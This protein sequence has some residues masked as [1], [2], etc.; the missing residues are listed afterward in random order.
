[1]LR[2]ARQWSGWMNGAGTYS[3]RTQ[4]YFVG[5]SGWVYDWNPNGIEWYVKNSGL[6][7]V[8]LNASFYRFPSEKMVE[9]WARVASSLRWSIK[10][11][12]LITHRF[13]LNE[14]ALEYWNKFYKL[15][16]P[17]EERGLVDFYLFQLPPRYRPTQHGVEKLEKFAQECGLGWRMAVEWRNLEWF[18]EEWVVWARRNEITVVSV[19]SPIGIFYAKSG[20]YVYVRFHGRVVWYA[21]RYTVEELAE[22]AAKLLALKPSKLYAFFNNNHDMLDNARTFLKMLKTIGGV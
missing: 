4:L 2:N 22:A 15:F 13:M 21:Y 7:A 1:M 8:E 5:T 17:M 9:K 12:Q 6:N 20:P 11:N 3:P 18:K 16:K 19:D 10:V 14:K